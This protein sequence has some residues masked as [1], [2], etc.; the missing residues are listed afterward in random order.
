MACLKM[1][2]FKGFNKE[3]KTVGLGKG[4]E[5]YGGYKVHIESFNKG[6]YLTSIEGLFY[7]GFCKYIEK[8]FGLNGKIKN[9]L[10]I[11]EICLAIGNGKDVIA[12]VSP[13]IRNKE[14]SVVKKGG[15]LVLIT[16]YDLINKKISIHNPS[17]YF[18]KSQEDYWLT[19]KEFN[20]F[21]ANRG[22][23]IK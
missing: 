21:F 19:F 5:R 3:Y 22:I 20:K 8:E 6:E 4:C 10:T 17:G 13:R 12:S 7:K 11:N 15:H 9:L 18:R 23:I 1:I 14:D 2:L 16:G